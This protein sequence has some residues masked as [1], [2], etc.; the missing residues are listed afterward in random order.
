MCVGFVKPVFLFF[1]QNQRKANSNLNEPTMV[2]VYANGKELE[3]TNA[4][5][6]RNVLLIQDDVNKF[7]MVLAAACSET[8][9]PRSGNEVDTVLELFPG[10]VLNTGESSALYLLRDQP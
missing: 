1:T 7:H 6:V 5:C 8:T 10:P 3:I 2:V 9:T 4:K